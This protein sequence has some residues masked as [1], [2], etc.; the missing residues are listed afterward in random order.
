MTKDST[1]SK[2]WETFTRQEGG[3]L[4]HLPNNHC[5]IEFT[6]PEGVLTLRSYQTLWSFSRVPRTEMSIELPSKTDFRF[7]IRHQ[8]LFSGFFEWMGVEDLIV[9]N[10]YFDDNFVIQGYPDH[11]VIDFF[12]DKEISSL[13][14]KSYELKFS[15][16]GNHLRFKC[17]GIIKEIGKLDKLHLVFLVCIKKMKHMGVI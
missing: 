1:T 9:G 7:H 15:Y 4:L 14:P 17:H 3:T 5:K 11:Q 10:E 6:L 12:E 2:V 13:I 16:D 8:G